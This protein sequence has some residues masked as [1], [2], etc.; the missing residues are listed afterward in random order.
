MNKKSVSADL[1]AVVVELIQQGR[2]D[3]ARKLLIKRLK[4]RPD[5]PWAHYALGSILLIKN[6]LKVAEKHLKSAVALDPKYVDAHNHLGVVYARSGA[7]SDVVLKALNKALEIDPNHFDTLLNLGHFHL[8]NNKNELAEEMFTRAARVKPDDPIVVNNLGAVKVRKNRRE[9]ALPFYRRALELMPDDVVC[10]ANYLSCL[11][12]LK[13]HD[14]LIAALNKIVGKQLGAEVFSVFAATRLYAMWES[15]R[16][17]LEQMLPQLEADHRDPQQFSFMEINMVALAM[18][19]IDNDLLF[20]IHKLAGKAACQSLRGEAL[21]T[22]ANTAMPAKRW[23]VGYISPDFRSHVVSSF[24]RALINERAK[25]KFEIYCYSNTKY[26]DHITDEY[27]AAADVFV[28]ITQMGNR[29]LADL[30]HENGIHFLVDLTGYTQDSR[31][32]VMCYRPAPVQIMYMGYPY[33]SGIPEV[34]YFISDSYL[35]GPDNQKYFVEKHIHLPEAFTSFGELNEQVIAE[36]PPCKNNTFITFGSLNSIYKVNEEVIGLWARVLSAVPNSKMII[37]HPYCEPEITR[38]NILTEFEKNNIAIERIEFVWLQHPD[39]G[40]LRYYND[41]DIALDTFPLT[42]GTT[43]IDAIWMGVPVIT[44][45]GALYHQRLSYSILKNVGIDLDGLIAFNK[46]DYVANAVALAENQCLIVYYRHAIPAS[47]RGSILCDPVR[48]SR[49]VEIAYLEAWDKKFPTRPV[50]MEIVD[51]EIE[52]HLLAE[53]LHIATPRDLNDFAN[54][55]LQEQPGWYETEWR[56]ARLLINPGAR[57][58]DIGAEY[59]QYAIPLAEAATAGGKLWAVVRFPHEADLLARSIL[60]N[61]LSQASIIIRGDSKLRLDTQMVEH[62]LSDIDFVRIHLD[63]AKKKIFEEGN[64]FFKLNS[65]LVMFAISKVDQKY[66]LGLADEFIRRGYRIFRLVPELN[67]L[68]PFEDESELDVFAL[69]LFA[70]KTGSVGLLSRQGMLIDRIETVSDLPG[71]HVTAWQDYLKNTPYATNL[72]SGWVSAPEKPADWDVYWVALN[73]VA[74]AH[75]QSSPMAR[76]YACLQAALG[77]LSLLAQAQPRLPRLAT[78]IN[79]LVGLGKREQAVNLLNQVC[80]AIDTSTDIVIDEPIMP[81]SSE[82]GEYSNQME[83]GQKIF[84]SMLRQREMLRAFSSYFTGEDALAAINEMRL[85]KVGG[86]EMQLR[87]RLI[88]GRMM[89]SDSSSI[90]PAPPLQRV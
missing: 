37:N 23:R 72:L 30:I 88:R 65:P 21:K 40:H 76:R 50:N 25:Y 17:M 81:L 13:R 89:V 36:N 68:I 29:E 39:G 53:G 85:L 57:V 51:N 55:V 32:D 26:P 69:N 46:D 87:E 1:I 82:I 59:G 86:G 67:C 49:H 77:I 61:E 66:D 62:N 75:N 18:P 78:M 79:V 19:E 14:E 22:H 90:H 28:D 33:T 38:K 2:H 70:A 64:E 5:D 10:R 84:A 80:A 16:R 47:L 73:L 42:G 60:R 58:L 31:T 35:D 15:S 8:R 48:L 41:I 20:K 43:T 56:F 9:E 44:L 12:V 83:L 74:L 11:R 24:L 54:Y 6:D 63:F 52:W 45:A 27:R 34:D 7:P 71:S 3:E 4:Y